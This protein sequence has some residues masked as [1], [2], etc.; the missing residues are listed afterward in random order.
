MALTSSDLLSSGHPVYFGTYNIAFLLECNLFTYPYGIRRAN[1]SFLHHSWDVNESLLLH[2]VV[3]RDYWQNWI[4]AAYL[5]IFARVLNFPRRNYTYERRGGVISGNNI[6]CNNFSSHSQIVTRHCFVFVRA[7][8]FWDFSSRDII[9][10]GP[11]RTLVAS[12]I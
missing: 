10:M 12:C 9:S 6:A 5:C 7:L 2:L 8:F 4:H 11:W 3:N 1:H